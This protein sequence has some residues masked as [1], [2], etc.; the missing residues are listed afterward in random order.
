MAELTDSRAKLL[1]GEAVRLLVQAGATGAA[2]TE[3]IQ[4]YT[5]ILQATLTAPPPAGPADLK[6]QIKEAMVEVLQELAPPDRHS[7]GASRKRVS[8]YIDGVKT[9]L[10]LPPELMAHAEEVAGT[11]KA[12]RQRIHEFANAKPANHDNLSAWVEEQLQA[13]ILLAN[14][15]VDISH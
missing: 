3:F 14:V 12:L 5:T 6:A 11:K 2:I 1:L 4:G 10:S 13:Y 7:T 9:M 8:V 15:S